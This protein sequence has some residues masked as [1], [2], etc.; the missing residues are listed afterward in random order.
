VAGALATGFIKR[1]QIM[2]L[3]ELQQRIIDSNNGTKVVFAGPGSGK[4]RVLI[5]Q[6]EQYVKQGIN[7]N[8]IT[9]ITYTNAGAR[10]LRDR[11]KDVCVP[12]YVGTLHGFVLRL[13]TQYGDLV[14]L[15]KNV[16]LVDVDQAGSTLLEIA[17][18]MGVKS[19]EAKLIE[20]VKQY[21][22]SMRRPNGDQLVAMEYRKQL[23]ASSALTF[24]MVLEEGLALVQALSR[25]KIKICD[26]LLI[27]EA[28][29][30]SAADA[31]IY[32]A[33]DCA[34]KFIV[35]DPDQRI[36][37]FRG[38]CD[39]FER[40]CASPNSWVMPN[41]YRSTQAICDRA[42]ELILNNSGPHMRLESA[43]TRNGGF[44]VRPGNTS[45]DELFMILEEVRMGGDVAVLCRTNL[46]A[47]QIRVYLKTFGVTVAEAPRI[48]R[49]KDW[50]RAM[51]LLSVLANPYS[52][53]A[54]F[55]YVLATDGSAAANKL[56]HEASVAMQPM[57]KMCSYFDNMIAGVGE[58]LSRCRISVETMQL[59]HNTSAELSSGGD[60]TINHLLLACR[61]GD[62][63]Q[64]E[65][66][67]VVVTTLHASKGREWDRVIIA[68]CEDDV[69]PG[70][71][72]EEEERR[73]FYVGITRARTHL[74]FTF[75]KQR[76]VYRGPTITP[77]APTPRI[78]SR[79]IQ[80]AG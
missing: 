78:A 32:E 30:S 31:A 50:S 75:S 79:F 17:R 61:A 45:A 40:L 70:T 38:S 68:G 47:N 72:D 44:A 60:W 25:L 63:G 49:P 35:G 57:F 62:F 18:G 34:H 24:E 16:T 48:E 11:I 6:V 71:G 23:K 29:D 73:L 19:S 55:Q 1:I 28:Q 51:L 8:G 56:K 5:A 33:I 20:Q 4:S 10:V 14:G 27:D 26:C 43:I 7:P 3:D 15:Q 76:S 58:I 52:D 42:H 64:R 65:T 12:G 9:V 22:S 39:W 77:G 66:Q 21:R 46:L 80:Q 36:Y 54:V 53:L 69:L 59:I 13:I 2:Q 41:N 74:T 67:G 37:S